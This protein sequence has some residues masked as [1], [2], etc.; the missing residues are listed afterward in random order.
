MLQGPQEGL[1]GLLA[2]LSQGRQGT[3]E[4][5]WWVVWWLRHWD[6]LLQV[7]MSKYCVDAEAEG[8]DACQSCPRRDRKTV[9]SAGGLRCIITTTTTTT[10]ITTTNT[11][12]TTT[13]LLTTTAHPATTTKQKYIFVVL[14]FLC[15]LS[16]PSENVS[17]FFFCFRGLLRISGFC[18]CCFFRC[19]FIFSWPSENS[20]SFFLFRASL[21]FYYNCYKY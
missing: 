8:C 3:Q 11:T 4:C 12:N 5:V 9:L 21:Y 13:L 6:N 17:F 14:L 15:F 1:G 20:A 16:W 18:W 10:T 7:V 2:G 19:S